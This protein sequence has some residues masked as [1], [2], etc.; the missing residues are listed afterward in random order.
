[1]LVPSTLSPRTLAFRPVCLSAESPDALEE[2]LEAQA[3][4]ARHDLVASQLDELVD[5]RLSGRR[6][7]DATR[8]A[9]REQLL[10]GCDEEAH[11][12][13]VYYPWSGRLLRVLPP[14]QLRELR[15]DRNRNKITRA[16][17]DRLATFRVGVV[18]LSVGNAV[19][20]TLAQEGVGGTLVLADFDELSTSNL[21]RVRA[22]LHAVGLPK[23]VLAARQIAEIDPFV[24]VRCLHDGLTPDN[25]PAFLDGLDLVVDECDGLAM[26]VRLRQAARER[27]LPVVMET[28]DRGTLDVERFDLEPG[29]DLL[30]GRLPD[31]PPEDLEHLSDGERLALV[32]EA[33]GYDL[34]T[35]AA[36]S[37]LE[38]G[39]SLSTWPQLA[40]DVAHGGASVTA[41]VRRILLGEDVPSGRRHVETGALEVEAVPEP[42]APVRPASPSGLD[43]AVEVALRAAI[44]APSGG[45][46]QPWSFTVE[47]RRIVVHHDRERSRSLL[48]VDGL[49]GLVSVGMA[50]ESLV[51]GASTAGCQ[52]EVEWT[53][54]EEGPVAL[55]RLH[56]GG[57]PD[58]LAPWIGR[59]F[60][61]RRTPDH[62]PLSSVERRRLIEASGGRARLQLVEDLPGRTRLGR[63]IGAVDRVRFLHER[64]HAEMWDEVRWSD[65]DAA[66]RPDGISLAEMAAGAGDTPVL[67]L[68][69][70]PDVAAFLRRSGGGRRL[71]ELAER[72]AASASAVALFSL[73]G[74]SEAPNVLEAGRG[75]YRTWLTACAAGLAI[76]PIGVA[77]YMVRH[78]GTELEAGYSVRDRRVLRGADIALSSAFPGVDAGERLLLFRV[79][80]GGERYAATN[81]RPLADVVNVT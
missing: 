20:T 7:S 31:V 68:L 56:E 79:L 41:T 2:L 72:W 16:E 46:C 65:A 5:A 35:R 25:L 1:M 61:D 74:A 11:G 29:R 66:A 23:T 21:N 17:Q 39:A 14:R 53:G 30:H 75:I 28:S 49:A 60:T 73:A 50:V 8:R 12:V 63:W 57:Q 6:Q 10:R 71:G 45:N 67:K 58:A 80:Q 33:V 37:M 48:D 59:R 13:W 4:W 69:R 62:R 9:V 34:S 54:A 19:V 26:K 47:G 27:G 77:A 18:G 51:L 55:V 38:I 43:P 15:L 40:S 3:V 44:Q 70:R 24:D 22:P 36:A 81:R 78:L 64:L 42:P 76:Q 52:A 32:A